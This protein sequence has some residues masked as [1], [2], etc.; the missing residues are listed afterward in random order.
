MAGETTKPKRRKTR[1]RAPRGTGTI[2]F[3]ERR[4]RW[5]GR[6]PVGRSPTGKTLYKE[7]W[8]ET[9][10]EVVKKLEAATPP[11]P[12]ITV[13]SWANRWLESISVRTGTRADY[14]VSF[15]NHI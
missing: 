14:L 3:N 7:F 5:V 8:A 12:E 13:A 15:D 10:G 2:F 4:Q 1:Q 6:K 11:G 9:Q